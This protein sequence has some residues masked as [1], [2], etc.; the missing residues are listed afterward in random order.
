M[1]DKGVWVYDHTKLEATGYES[2]GNGAAVEGGRGEGVEVRVKNP[3]VAL[4][5][6]VQ[7]RVSEP[8]PSRVWSKNERVSV[9]RPSCLASGEGG[10]SRIIGDEI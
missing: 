7:A 8:L 4:E 1:M 5:R 3:C 6:L 9:S 10:I 2:G